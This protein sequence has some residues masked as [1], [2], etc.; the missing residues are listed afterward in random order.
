VLFQLGGPDSLDAVEPFLYNLFSDPEIIDF[1]FARLARP[2]LA[3]LI[4]SRRARKVREHYASIGGK[5]PI[6]ELT[7]LQAAALERELRKT[8]DARVFVAMRYWSPLTEETARQVEAFDFCELVLLPLYPQ[9]SKTTTGS[10]LNEWRRSYKPSETR[11]SAVRIVQDFH[12]DHAYIDAVVERINQALARFSDPMI[13]PAVNLEWTRHERYSNTTKV[14]I[15]AGTEAL[16]EHSGSGAF[17]ARQ[18]VD[19][20]TSHDDVHL[21]FSAHGLPLSVIEAGD[22]YQTQVAATSKLVMERGGWP[23]PHR[24]CY[25]SRVGPGRWLRPSLGEGLHSFAAH[26][27][28]KV[29]VI[30]ISFVSDHVETLSEID[31]EARELARHLGIREFGVT[32]ALNDSPKFIQALAGLVLREVGVKAAV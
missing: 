28:S 24:I 19:A 1:P 3:R 23:N 12:G 29:L 13:Q 27:A 2:T 18:K 21:V 16:S 25:Q 30:P 7:E 10:S 14:G 31:I 32:S 17:V 20:T 11:P 6:R 8:L 9:Y 4:S 15:C 22:P 5:S 26:G